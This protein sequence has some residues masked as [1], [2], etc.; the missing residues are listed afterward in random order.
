MLDSVRVPTVFVDDEKHGTVVHGVSV[1][2]REAFETYSDWSVMAVCGG[3]K[4]FVRRKE[5]IRSLRVDESRWGRVVHE[6]AAISRHAHIGRNVYVGPHATIHAGAVIDDHVVVMAGATLHHE[7]VVGRYAIVCAGTILAGGVRVGE[8]AFV[9]AGA[10]IRQEIVV[11]EGA[12]VGLGAVVVRDVA[13][14]TTVVG[15]PARVI[16]RG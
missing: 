12:L 15:N 6:T 10:R 7:A 3:P 5:T 4:S 8:E 16:P 1:M 14:R 11:G 9:G 2:G 13:P